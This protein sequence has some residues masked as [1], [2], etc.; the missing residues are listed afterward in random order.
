VRH[1][2]LKDVRRKVLERALADGADMT[3][4]WRRGVFC[5]LDAGDVDVTAFLAELRASGYDGW[6]VVE[7]DRILAMDDDPRE[8]VDA[9]ARNRRWL[10]EHAGL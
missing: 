6:L 1:V 9:Q 7:Q 10:T 4:L 3:E 2:H 8:P 5:E